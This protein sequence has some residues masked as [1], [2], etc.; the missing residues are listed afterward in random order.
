VI[1]KAPDRPA[2][3]VGDDPDDDRLAGGPGRGVVQ[4]EGARPPA[5][6]TGH[7]L[8]AHV[9]RGVAVGV[10]DGQQFRPARPLQVPS[11]GLGR[12][13]PAEGRPFGLVEGHGVPAVQDELA[14]RSFGH[15]ASHPVSC[16]MIG[17]VRTLEAGAIIGQ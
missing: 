14:G 5:E 17:A 12:G 8:D 10:V 4:H 6:D 16:P 7:P 1:K 9:G 11:E 2:S 3:G 15:P 13:H